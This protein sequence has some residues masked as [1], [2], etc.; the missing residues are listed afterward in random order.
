[1]TPSARRR[2]TAKLPGPVSEGAAE[3]GFTVE[4]WDQARARPELIIG[5]ASDLNVAQAIFVSAQREY[6][7]RLLVLKQGERTLL[8][9]G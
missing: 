8:T 6:P 3:L 1:M 4:L 2:S 7:G 5:R 9:S